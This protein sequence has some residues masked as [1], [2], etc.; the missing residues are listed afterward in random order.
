M[1]LNRWKR[2]YRILSLGGDIQLIN[3]EPLSEESENVMCLYNLI[4]SSEICQ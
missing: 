2:D 3:S 1:K 4:L